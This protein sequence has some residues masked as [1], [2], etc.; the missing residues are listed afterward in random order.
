MRAPELV[1]LAMER[2]GAAGPTELADR[3]GMTE[4]RAPEKISRWLAGTHEPSYEATLLLLDAAGWL[5]G[6]DGQEPPGDE[7]AER[8]RM[9]PA[10]EVA[11]Q[12]RKQS[13]LLETLTATAVILTEVAEGLKAETGALQDVVRELGVGQR[14]A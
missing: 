1:R 4:R 8:R 6:V 3:I 7:L 14:P 11:E 12:L 2:T 9:T 5:T 13:A 10:E